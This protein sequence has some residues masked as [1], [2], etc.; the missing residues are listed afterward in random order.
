MEFKAK[1]DE[2]LAEQVTKSGKL[3]T[4]FRAGGRATK[5]YPNKEDYSWWVDNGQDMVQRWVEWRDGSGWE[6]FEPQPGVPAIELGMNV[7]L[8]GVNIKMFLDRVMIN[9]DGELVILDLKT[10]SRTP[11]SDLQLGFYAMGLEKTFGIRP[12]WGTYWMAR[13][14]TTTELVDLDHYSTEMITEIVGKFKIAQTNGVFLPNFN[15]CQMCNVV[16]YC[17]FKTPNVK[18]K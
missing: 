16:E 13:T 11:S 5:A 12:K 3:L 10:G 7:N 2:L 1:F 17:R 4:E 9:G 18:E 14:G 6:F 15:H 8:E